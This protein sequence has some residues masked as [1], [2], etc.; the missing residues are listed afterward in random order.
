MKTTLILHYIIYKFI[1]FLKKLSSF[2]KT[3]KK[4]QLGK[5]N[6]RKQKFFHINCKIINGI[7][8]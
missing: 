6:K 1:L 3:K 7:S 5:N 4:E 2:L 8:Y